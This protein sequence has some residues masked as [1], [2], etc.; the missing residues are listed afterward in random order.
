MKKLKKISI[1]VLVI[2]FGAIGSYYVIAG[3]V[4]DSYADDSKVANTWNTSTSTSG[5]IKLEAKS[6][7]FFNWHCTA[8]TTC[9]SELEDGDYIIVGRED[10]PSTLAWKTSRTSCDIPQCGIDAG[11]DDNLVEDN[12]IDFTDYPA[13]DYCKSIGARLPTYNETECMYNNQ[14]SFGDNF[15]NSYYATSREYDTD[16]YWSNNIVTSAHLSPYK[17]SVSNVRCV[18]GW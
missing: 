5:E 18:K 12:T 9:A 11:Q 13:R 6:C 16:E 17:D 8:S 14:T 7:D 2:T 3:I 15:I 1:F 4:T 10:A